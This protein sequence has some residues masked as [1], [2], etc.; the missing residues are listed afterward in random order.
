[1]STLA[2]LTLSLDVRDGP[3]LVLSSHQGVHSWVPG[4]LKRESVSLTASAFTAL[5]PPTGATAVLIELPTSAVSLTLKGATGDTGIAL[6][7]ASAALGLPVLLPL[8]SSAVGILNGGS[9]AVVV[10]VAW[11]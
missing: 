7:P 11:L 2:A 9:S 6:T 8:S 1:M 5:S 4:A 10:T 3:A